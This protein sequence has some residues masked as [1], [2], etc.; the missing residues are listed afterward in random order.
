M[1]DALTIQPR[2]SRPPSVRITPPVVWVSSKSSPSAGAGSRACGF[3]HRRMDRTNAFDA[4]RSQGRLF[5]RLPQ[6]YQPERQRTTALRAAASSAVRAA[7][8]SLIRPTA[9]LRPGCGRPRSRR[10]GRTPEL[11]ASTNRGCI[12]SH[13]G[14][15]RSRTPSDAPMGVGGRR[16]MLHQRR[17]PRRGTGRKTGCRGTHAEARDVVDHTRNGAGDV[18]ENSPCVTSARS[19]LGRGARRRRLARIFARGGRE[20][21]G[22]ANQFVVFGGRR[23]NRLALTSGTTDESLRAVA[24]NYILTTKAPASTTRSASTTRIVAIHKAREAIRRGNKR[25]RGQK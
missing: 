24:T 22:T 17:W 6:S 15:S 19:S 14:T 5:L 7:S 4:A 9:S 16:W 10:H 11:Q 13:A 12:A 18:A 20:S 23:G 21:A 2:F 25:K 1:T 8:P 3:R